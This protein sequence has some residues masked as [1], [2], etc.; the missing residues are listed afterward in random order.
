MDRLPNN[1][2]TSTRSRNASFSLSA[3]KQRL[4]PFLHGLLQRQHVCEATSPYAEHDDTPESGHHDYNHNHSSGVLPQRDRTQRRR[5]VI[6]A[7]KRTQSCEFEI[8]RKSAP[9]PFTVR[10]LF[11]EPTISNFLVGPLRIVPSRDAACRG[12]EK[13][14]GWIRAP[15]APCRFP[16]LNCDHRNGRSCSE[17]RGQKRKEESPIRSRAAAGMRKRVDCSE[18]LRAAIMEGRTRAAGFGV[19][20]DARFRLA[21]TAIHN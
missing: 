10:F 19:S 2:H 8:T 16:E 9:G 1:S 17:T 11:P 13:R 18:W 7:S 12:L 20:R 6:R 15:A 3:A 4:L 14:H 21:S 5:T